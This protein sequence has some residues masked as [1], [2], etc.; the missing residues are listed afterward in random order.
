MLMTTFNDDHNFPI[1]V[2][3]CPIVVEGSSCLC[4][5]AACHAMIPSIL[6]VMLVTLASGVVQFTRVTIQNQNNYLVW[7]VL[8]LI[9]NFNANG[10]NSQGNVSTQLLRT[11]SS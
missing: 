8:N 7:S 11:L 5:V 4:S 3:N 9:T 6:L 1:V 10:H 2:A